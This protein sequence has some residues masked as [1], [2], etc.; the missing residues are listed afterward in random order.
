MRATTRN[1][2]HETA[3]CRLRTALD[4]AEWEA[5]PAGPEAIQELSCEL[6]AVYDR[7]GEEVYD[8]LRAGRREEGG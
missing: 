6:I 7:L 3:R 2:A 1:E 4:A 8:Y 5:L